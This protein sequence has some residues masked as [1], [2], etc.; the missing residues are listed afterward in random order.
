MDF[1]KL[2]TRF[3]E[4]KRTRLVNPDKTRGQNWTVTPQ[5]A[6]PHKDAHG[7]CGKYVVVPI[8]K[9]RCVCMCVCVCVWERVSSFEVLVCVCGGGVPHSNVATHRRR[10]SVSKKGFHVHFNADT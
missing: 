7:I 1:Y 4:L 8:T 10:F 6:P 2:C 3:E 5:S 9:K